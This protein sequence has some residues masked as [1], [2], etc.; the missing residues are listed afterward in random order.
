[1]THSKTNPSK[2]D[3]K[4]IKTLIMILAVALIF[5]ACDKDKDEII[6]KITDAVFRAYCLENFD[7]DRD[8]KISVAEADAV[9]NIDIAYTGINSLGGIEY[10]SNLEVL[11]CNDNGLTTLNVSKNTALTRLCCYKN[12][13]TTLDVSKNTAL[14]FLHCYN[15]KLTTLDVSK[16][17]ALLYLNCDGNE[18]TTLDV[19]KNT[20]LF[21]LDFP[22][23]KLTTLDVSKNTALTGLYCFNNKLTTLDISKNK[24]LNGLH[25]QNNK[26]TTLDISKNT[27]LKELSCEDNFINTIWVWPGFNTGNPGESIRYCSYDE[28]VSFVVKQEGSEE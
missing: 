14:V 22:N 15:N 7:A 20:A 17:T 12:K 11:E 27:S 16:N 3:M 25:C 21:I 9:V 23:N 28:S 5:A 13:L 26:L 2:D 6:D 10:F 19:S 4:T 8:G 1:M 18:L 24:A